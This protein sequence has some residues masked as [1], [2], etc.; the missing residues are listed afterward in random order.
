[1]E[2]DK[3]GDVHGHEEGEDGDNGGADHGNHAS[4][5]VGMDDKEDVG[6]AS[7][8]LVADNADATMVVTDMDKLA[9]CPLAVATVISLLLALFPMVCYQT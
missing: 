7:D 9:R 2:E 6:P 5:E 3:D 1:V 4:A 8:D